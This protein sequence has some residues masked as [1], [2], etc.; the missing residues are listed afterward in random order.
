M[1]HRARV[2]HLSSSLSCAD[3]F[4]ALYGKALK[5]NAL[6]PHD[7]DRDRFILSKAHAASAL[8]SALAYRGFISDNDLDS[9]A[10]NGSKLAEHP[11]VELRGCEA[12]CGSLGHGAGIATG[13]ALAAR[14]QGR[15]YRVF[16]LLG[17]AECGEG[18]IW[19]AATIAAEYRLRNLCFVIDQNGI[20]GTD[21]CSGRIG[22]LRAKFA[23]FGWYSIGT[24]GH[25]PELL[26]R[27]LDM[28]G[29]YVQP[30]ALVCRTCK[31]YGV[32]FAAA[33]GLLWHYKPPSDE[34]LRLAMDELK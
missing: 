33:S 30:L 18:S 3:I 23:A 27:Q 25:D 1:H 4:A 20:G 22:D 12:A 13:M 11:S 6:R 8:Y 31:G 10:E 32:S 24:N 19:E 21:D 2:G 17:D 14:M 26:A 15:D 9:F 5:V 34:E 16:C 28:V 7:P 29:S